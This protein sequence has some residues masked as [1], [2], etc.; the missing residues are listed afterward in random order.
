MTHKLRF[1]ILCLIAIGVFFL[2]FNIDKKYYWYDETFTSLRISG[3]RESEVVAELATGQ[4]FTPQDLQRYQHPTP[5]KTL[6]DTVGGLAAEEPQLT[7]LY[8]V[9]ARFWVQTFGYSIATIRSLSAIIS[10]L[11]FP[12][13]YWLCLE[14]F[15]SSVTGWLS[16]GLIAVSPFH[17]LYGQEARPYSLWTV[18]ILVSTAALLRA[19]RVQKK[20]WWG[21]YILSLIVGLYT[22]FLMALVAIS[23][24]IYVVVTENCRW[25][26]TLKSFIL[27]LVI[28]AISFLPWIISIIVNSKSLSQRLGWSENSIKFFPLVANWAKNIAGGYFDLNVNNESPKIYLIPSAIVV[29]AIV[30]L[31]IYA[32]Y[33]LIRHTPIQVWLLIVALV[34]VTAITIILPDL[35]LG[36][37]R[38][39]KARYLIPCYLGIRLAVS[40]YLAYQIFSRN[41]QASKI[42][43][44]LITI[45]LV[46]VGLISCA[47]S[48]NAEA[49]WIKEWGEPNP[50]IAKI[51]NQTQHPLVVSN[52]LDSSYGNLVSLSYLLEP[53]V[54]FY[55]VTNTKIT[56]IPSGFSD[57]LIY[58]AINMPQSEVERKMNLLLKPLY[59]DRHQYVWLWKPK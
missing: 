27:S 49:W 7:P 22:H 25:T 11:I 19:I 3:Y 14:L 10:L 23:H 42:Q 50:K 48:S 15:Q 8:F 33:F 41:Y 38:S 52:L 53:K 58:T 9:I 26:K 35:I 44:Q 4:I 28:S 57:I 43:A 56:Q 16:V 54:R 55:L 24:I 34:A 51:I 20:W 59:R 47:V 13:I 21:V 2:F 12:S 30:S 5:E 17:V 18:T 36:G 39:T 45:S 1:S 6:V 37:I 31:V 29:L 32:L 40:Y 46:F